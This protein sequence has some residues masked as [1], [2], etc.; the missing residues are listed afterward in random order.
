MV[1]QHHCEKGGENDGCEEFVVEC[2]LTAGE[3]C[4]K[5][6]RKKKGARSKTTRSSSLNFGIINVPY[7]TI[8][9]SSR[10]DRYDRRIEGTIEVEVK[11]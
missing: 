8:T 9:V 6:G 4:L 7:I 5:G 11:R 3:R 10:F 2:G 1:E